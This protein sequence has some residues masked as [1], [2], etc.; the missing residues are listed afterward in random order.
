M[1]AH[2]LAQLQ[3]Y[4]IWWNALASVN[5][6]YA[7]GTHVY[8]QGKHW[9]TLKLNPFGRKGICYHKKEN[10]N[11]KPSDLLTITNMEKNKTTV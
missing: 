2:N 11:Q 3:F 5:A 7:Y 9:Y 4:G 6:K 10:S 1:T 8:M